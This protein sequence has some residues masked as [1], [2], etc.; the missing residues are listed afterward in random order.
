M[1]YANATDSELSPIFIEREQ[2]WRNGA[3]VYQVLVDR[4]APSN[5]IDSKRLLYPKPKILRSWQETPE[6]GTYLEKEALWSHEIEFWG[7]DLKSLTHKLDHIK[8]LGADVLYLNPIHYAYTNHKY[9]SLDFHQVSPEFG[10]RQDVKT[11]TEAV[12]NLGMKIVLDGVFNHMGR[13]ADIYQQASLDFK[14]P[15]RNWFCFNNTY[16]SGHRSWN[17]AVNL[18]ELNLENEAVRKHIWLDE[19]SVVQ[20]YLKDGI[21]GWRLDVAHDIGFY[22]LDELTN[23]VHTCKPEAL[24]V[25]EIWCYPQQWFPSVDGVMNFTAREIIWRLCEGKIEPHVAAKM[26]E[27]MIQDAGI[28]HL[29]KSWLVLDNHDTPRLAN[30]LPDRR[31]QKLAQLLQFCFP[32]APNVYYGS[33][34][35]MQGGEDPEMRGPMRWDWVTDDN[36]HLIWM[37]T[38]IHLR[39]QHRAL[40]IGNYRPVH[41]NKLLA[42]ERYT[43]KVEESVLCICNPNE[44]QITEYLMVPNSKLMNMGG[45]ID[46]LNNA[47]QTIY[48]KASVIEVTV[49]P[50]GTLLLSPDVSETHGYSTYKRVL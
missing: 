28:E 25:G 35:G 9:D 34:L 22:Y 50:L 48:I 1:N 29:L 26:F 23:A 20:S 44:E 17:N 40:K 7:G 49:P 36:E 11:L 47:R 33:E 5:D 14:S 15:Y 12:H 38:L 41:S 6:H 18:P 43:D 31:R 30:M 37:K 3:I 27:Q 4:F 32:G 46:L 42:F 24:V 10:N 39:Q 2:D 45:M 16:P 8:S 21:D 19:D 13:N